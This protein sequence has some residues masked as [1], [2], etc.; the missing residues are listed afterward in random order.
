MSRYKEQV[1]VQVEVEA[2]IEGRVEAIGL[3]DG[4]NVQ[5]TPL[6]RQK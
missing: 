5:E 6:P 3:Q 4:Q 2:Q 1:Q